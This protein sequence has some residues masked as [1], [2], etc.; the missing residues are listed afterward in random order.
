LQC[1]EQR[2]DSTSY[3]LRP[4]KGNAFPGALNLTVKTWVNI[5]HLEV[6]F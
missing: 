6:K 1:S 4:R 3:N 2:K 5:T